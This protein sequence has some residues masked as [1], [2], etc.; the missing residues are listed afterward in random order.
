VRAQYS[1]PILLFSALATA[2]PQDPLQFRVDVA[3]MSLNV[4]VDDA[5]GRP[6]TNLTRNDFSISEDGQPRD[7]QV[8]ESAES[9]Y[10][11]L[12]LFDRSSSTEEQWP[13]LV[14][15]LARFLEKL[16]AQHRVAVAAFDDKAE[17]LV[18]WRSPREFSRAFEIPSNS[19]GT[20]LYGALEWATSELRKINGRKGIIVFSDG[21]DN[22]LSK[23]L[24]SFDRNGT[25][26]VAPMEE[27]DDF[28]K[29]LRTVMAG[30]SPVYFVAV[31]TDKNPDPREPFNSFNEKQRQAARLRMQMVADRSS[32]VLH[33][34]IRIEDVETLYATIGQELGNSYS[35]GFAPGK[36]SADGSFHRIEVRVGNKSLKVTQSS[37]G[38]YAR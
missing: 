27:D 2:T 34:P 36:F 9:P 30:R 3:F 14:R 6:V 19:G 35:L 13:Y 38:Y 15:A 37:D 22:R 16:P 1:I 17:M 25:P 18:K 26:S 11:I 28:I 21:V 33:L 4:S 24:V 20:N 8:F 23:K 12:L 5:S 7:I 32:G 31:N 29:M 10:N